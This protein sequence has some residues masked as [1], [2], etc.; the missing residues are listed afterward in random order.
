MYVLTH[1]ILYIENMLHLWWA[2][3]EIV[4]DSPAAD[5]ALSQ[6]CCPNL[7]GYVVCP[8]HIVGVGAHEHYPTK[9]IC[10]GDQKGTWEV[11]NLGAYPTG[12]CSKDM[13]NSTALTAVMVASPGRVTMH[14]WSS[15]LSVRDCA[16]HQYVNSHHI[17]TWDTLYVWLA[18]YLNN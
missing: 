8:R 16:V 2:C 15:I 3:C 6:G 1:C 12:C 17:R 11:K 14:I 9:N 5:V 7:W 13:S 10:N 4:Q 18:F